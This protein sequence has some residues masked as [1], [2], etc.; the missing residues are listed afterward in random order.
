VRGAQPVHLSG[1]VVRQCQSGVGVHVLGQRAER[2]AVSDG[3][4]EL[5]DD[6]PGARGEYLRSEDAP[7]VGLCDD[8][9][10]ALGMAGLD[11][12]A[13]DPKRRLN[14]V[15]LAVEAALPRLRLGEPDARK[16]GSVNVHQPAAS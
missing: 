7:P 12:R 2:D 15:D 16:S 14:A 6:L 1:H 13:V 10:G 4:D 3:S 8:L 9:R 11:A 5:L